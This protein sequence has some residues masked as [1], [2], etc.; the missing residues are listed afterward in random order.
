MTL[1]LIQKQL[2]AHPSSAKGG[3]KKRGPKDW[4]Q[5]GTYRSK[6]NKQEASFSW[7]L[8]A[9]GASD[10]NCI[11]MVMETCFCEIHVTVA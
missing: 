10:Q 6:K 3:G 4:R 7:S 5:R 9:F 8:G 11:R 2:A 1:V